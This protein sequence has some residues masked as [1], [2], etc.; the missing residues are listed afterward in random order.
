MVVSRV[1]MRNVWE[2]PIFVCMINPTHLTGDRW[3]WGATH[4]VAMVLEKFHFLL[5][6]GCHGDGLDSVGRVESSSRKD[7]EER[8]EREREGASGS[9][10]SRGVHKPDRKSI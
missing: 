4:F 2:G 9:R 6:E 10:F 3:V 8:R 7:T 5:G 1:A